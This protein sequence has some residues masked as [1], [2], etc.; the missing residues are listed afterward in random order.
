[1]W[2]TRYCPWDLVA[3]PCPLRGG[4]QPEFEPG[5]PDGLVDGWHDDDFVF[6]LLS[7]CEFCEAIL[8]R[9]REGSRIL[10]WCPEEEIWREQ[11]PGEAV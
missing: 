5:P 4:L 11:R 10:T 6:F 7:R 8:G 1:M 2:L 3:S 9:E